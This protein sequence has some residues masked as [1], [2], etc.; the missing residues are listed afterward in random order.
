YRLYSGTYNPTITFG[1]D[2][3][4]GLGEA[5]TPEEVWAEAQAFRD[6]LTNVYSTDALSYGDN[7]FIGFNG[8]KGAYGYDYSTGTQTSKIYNGEGYLLWRGN[9]FSSFN[10]P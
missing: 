9:F 5:S 1:A 3:V 6:G 8:S 7:Y 2:G 4:A 10:L